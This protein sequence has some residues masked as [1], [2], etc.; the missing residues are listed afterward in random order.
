[1]KG[2]WPWV[3]VIGGLAAAW[4]GLFAVFGGRV[5]AMLTDFATAPLSLGQGRSA[6]ADAGAVAPWPW[7]FR[8]DRVEI[9]CERDA[10]PR[11]IV[12]YVSAEGFALNGPARS[13]YPFIPND[14]LRS[15][16]SDL[17]GPIQF[18]LRLCRG[19]R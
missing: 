17:Y 1:M 12:E 10:D 19:R 5:N 13:R 2:R 7:P 16:R 4:L 11:V 3:Y 8:D 18:G 6:M 15:S 14:R 9:R